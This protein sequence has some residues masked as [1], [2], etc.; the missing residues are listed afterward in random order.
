MDEDKRRDYS[1][2]FQMVGAAKAKDCPRWV[3]LRQAT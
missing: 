3:D 1:I 2:L